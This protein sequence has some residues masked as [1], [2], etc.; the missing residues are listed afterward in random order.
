[1]AIMIASTNPFTYAWLA[2]GGAF[3]VIEGAAIWHRSRTPGGTLSS[4]V[5]R[6]QQHPV[7]KTLFVVGWSVLSLHFL[8]HWL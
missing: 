7:R 3:A 1:V 5:W 8:F 4:L 2:W 6:F